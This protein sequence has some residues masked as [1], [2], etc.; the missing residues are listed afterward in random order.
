MNLKPRSAEKA[1]SRYHLVWVFFTAQT[2]AKV[3]QENQYLWV[4]QL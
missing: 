2:E 4:L 1:N 3:I